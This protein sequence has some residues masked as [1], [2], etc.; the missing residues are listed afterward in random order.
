MKYIIYT[1]KNGTIKENGN[2]QGDVIKRRKITVL[3]HILTKLNQHILD[4]LHEDTKEK[5]QSVFDE[6]EQ[7]WIHSK[8]KNGLKMS[9][10]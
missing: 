8:S 5:V 3:N 9:L 1:K 4:Q 7:K 6:E 10:F 2:S